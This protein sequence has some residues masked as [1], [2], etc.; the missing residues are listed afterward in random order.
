MVTL[1]HRRLAWIG[2]RPVAGPSSKP[3]FRPPRAERC[4]YSVGT[5]NRLFSPA[6]AWPRTVPGSLS[7]LRWRHLY[8][9]TVDMR[10]PSTGRGDHQKA[11]RSVI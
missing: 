8:E 5:T 11:R 6:W 7:S 1:D 10:G 4:S 3:G 9:G 2:S